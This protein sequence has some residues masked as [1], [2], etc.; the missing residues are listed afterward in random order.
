MAQISRE[1]VELMNKAR[2]KDIHGLG[3]IIRE[4]ELDTKEDFKSVWRAIDMMLLKV[5]AVVTIMTSLVMVA[6]KMVGE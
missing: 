6:F 2:E 1:E 4:N 3:K 5:G